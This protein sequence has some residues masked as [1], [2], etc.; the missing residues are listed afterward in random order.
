MFLFLSDRIHSDTCFDQSQ[1]ADS[2]DGDLLVGVV[3]ILAHQLD[4]AFAIRLLDILHRDVLLTLQIERQQIHI[5]PKDIARIVQLLVEH[6][7]ATLQQRVHTI[8]RNVDRTVA[9][10]QVG[11]MNL[12]DRFVRGVVLEERDQS[13]RTLDTI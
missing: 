10:G 11:D 7:V 5:T 3:G 8:A 6:N 1:G 12:V 9:L 2:L 13:C 4:V